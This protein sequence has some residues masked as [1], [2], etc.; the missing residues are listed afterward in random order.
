MGLVVFM[1]GR[2]RRQIQ[3]RRHQGI[4]EEQA[5]CSQHAKTGVASNEAEA[6]VDAVKE[7]RGSLDSRPELHGDHVPPY[8]RELEGSPGHPEGQWRFELPAS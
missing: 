5:L 2:Y 8:S 3:L 7:K 4:A 6:V 1:C